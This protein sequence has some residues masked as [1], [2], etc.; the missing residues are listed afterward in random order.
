MLAA[1]AGVPSRA[2]SV[3]Y[4]WVRSAEK[5]FLI[6]ILG[7]TNQPSPSLA[8]RWNTAAPDLSPVRL[9]V[10]EHLS[11]PVF[12]NEREPDSCT[13]KTNIPVRMCWVL[14]LH[15]S[16]PPTRTHTPHPTLSEVDE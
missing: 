3:E 16:A 9:I 2:P 5:T 1:I 6:M 4:G 13:Q 15:L 8:E 7:P 12:P 11:Q 14:G 10:P